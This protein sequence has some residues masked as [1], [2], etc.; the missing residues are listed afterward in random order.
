MPSPALSGVALAW[1]GFVGISR[2]P[3][4]VRVA[5]SIRIG[6]CCDVR[7]VTDGDNT[8][9]PV[10]DNLH[11]EPFIRVKIDNFDSFP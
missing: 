9:V 11:S 8:V 1:R 4:S 10:A 2:A 3:C 7:G 5:V 6:I